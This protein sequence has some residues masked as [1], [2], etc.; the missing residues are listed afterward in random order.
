MRHD[1]DSLDLHCLLAIKWPSADSKAAHPIIYGGCIFEYYSHINCALISYLV[2]RKKNDELLK[3]L[4]NEA[5][6]IINATAKGMGHIAGCNCIFWEEKAE[7]HLHHHTRNKSSIGNNAALAGPPTNPPA[8]T[9]SET[10]A[11][12]VKEPRADGV[13]VTIASAQ[14]KADAKAAES[15]TANHRLSHALGFRQVDI[16]YIVPP[17]APQ[18]PHKL[19][20][21]L[22]AVLVTPNIPRIPFV[23]TEKYCIPSVVLKNF[24]SSIWRSAFVTGRITSPPDSDADF[25][26]ICKQVNVRQNI[27]LLELPWNIKQWTMV[28]L[29]EDFDEDLLKQFYE[30]LLVPN[31]PIEGGTF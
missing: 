21:W 30:H 2:V 22:L 7:Q 9:S 24:L 8:A 15:L 19:R 5:I 1:P 31:F 13:K 11:P 12:P 29:Y 25:R 16:Q 18:Y 17:V 28:D 14:S 3:N 26:R 23:E 20:N 10:P 4:I 27:P 6:E